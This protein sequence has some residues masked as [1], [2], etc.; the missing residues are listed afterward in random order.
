MNS[1]TLTSLN[2]HTDKRIDTVI[3]QAAEILSIRNINP[4]KASG[5]DGISGHMLRLGDD[6]IV[7]SSRIF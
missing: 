4:N 6:S 3:V 1:S 7:L 5:S 2:Y